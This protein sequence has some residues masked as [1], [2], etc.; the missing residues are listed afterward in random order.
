M[1]NLVIGIFDGPESNW[2]SLQRTHATVR[3]R[4]TGLTEIDLAPHI[5]ATEIVNDPAPLIDPVVP[6][7]VDARHP[8]VQ[9]PTHTVRIR[10]RLQRPFKRRS[11]MRIWI[12]R[13]T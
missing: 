8:A 13:N 4:H 3:A 7:N 11:Q 5:V 9:N 6:S 1:I 10:S 2:S 12:R